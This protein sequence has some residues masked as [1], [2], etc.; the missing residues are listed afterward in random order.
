MVLCE[1]VSTVRLPNWVLP[2]LP[3]ALLPRHYWTL[4]TTPRAHLCV[5]FSPAMHAPAHGLMVIPDGVRTLA[6]C[7]RRLVGFAFGYY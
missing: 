3:T 5:T 4:G 6:T 1:L 2:D 7:A